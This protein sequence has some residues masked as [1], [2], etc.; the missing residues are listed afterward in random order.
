[1]T[2][3][4]IDKFVGTA[5][6]RSFSVPGLAMELV[7]FLPKSAISELDRRGIDVLALDAAR[8]KGVPY[9]RSTKV[10]EKGVEKTV[11]VSVGY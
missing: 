2:K 10:V 7:R 1:M 6:E 11:Y 4:T 5:H 3:I 9:S 8:R